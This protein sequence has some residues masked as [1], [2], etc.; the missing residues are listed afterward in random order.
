[1]GGEFSGYGVTCDP[2]PTL[3]RG[4]SVRAEMH[5]LLLAGVETPLAQAKKK[6]KVGR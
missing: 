4:N 3:F 1:M 2:S 6:K 5:S